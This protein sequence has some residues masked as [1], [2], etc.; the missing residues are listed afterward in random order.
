MSANLLAGAKEKIQT[1]FYKP[2]FKFGLRA[3]AVPLV[4]SDTYL[5]IWSPCN[6]LN[7]GNSQHWTGEEHP[8]IGALRVDGTTYRFMGKDR[9]C[10]LP[11]IPDGDSVGGTKKYWTAAY[12][13]DK[14]DGK[15]TNTA[16]DDSAWKT[17]KA[18]FGTEDMP[19]IGTPWETEDIWIRRTF[20]LEEGLTEETLVLQYSH[21]DVFELYLNG[22]RLVKTGY[23]WKNDV[24]LTLGDEQKKKLKNGKNVIAAHC[25]NT[26]GGAYVDFN[27]YKKAK[28][29]G[30][31][32]PAVQQSVDVLPTQT[33]YTFTCG[34]VELDLIFTAPLLPGNP[35]LISTPVNYISYRVRPLDGN[36]H[37][38]QL[39]METTPQLAVN[40]LSQPVV[41]ERIEKNGMIYLKTGTVDQEITKRQGDGVRIDWGYAYLASGKGK[42]KDMNIGDYYGMKAGFVETGALLPDKLRGQQVSD[43]LEAIPALAYTDQ[44][45][46][47]NKEGKTGYLMIGY[48]D[49]YSVEYFHKRL[50]AWWKH[51]GKIDIFRAFET[52]KANYESIMKKCRE[53][54]F[55]L[56]DG[57]QKAGGDEYAELCA[58]VF[59]QAIAAHKLLQDEDGEWL[60]LSKENHSGGFINT[61][62]ITYPSAP[63]FLI[64]N[65]D[66]LKGM[67]NGIFRYSESGRW[68]KPYPAHD[69]G[70]YPNANGQHYGED[71]PVEEAGNMILLATALSVVEGNAAYAQKHWETLTTWANFLKEKGLD[72]DNQL[73]TDDFAGH[74]A[75]NA[76]L[77]IKAIL[78]IAGYGRMAQMLGKND[79]AND[80]F[81]EAKEMAAQW[82][83]M[84]KDED[85]YRLAF[86]RP[87][88]WSQKYNLV[89]DKLLD[90]NIFPPDIAELEI[91]YYL[92]RQVEH[93]YGLP[94]DSRKA[95]TKADWIFWVA[96]MAKERETF[97]EII[98]SVYRYANETQS[99]VPI[100][101]FY[102]TDDGKMVNFKAR[103]VVGG[104][105]MKILSDKLNSSKNK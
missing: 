23:T 82:I 33:Y 79:L 80:C 66:L 19:H 30:F 50:M 71:M 11:L 24:Q 28:R 18:A 39:Y 63:L 46:Q 49:I 105:Y 13:F 91:P 52:A 43:L 101:D 44:L 94:L 25:H 93:K 37:D 83:T 6:R 53:F 41:S 64:Y 72:P 77:S 100:S 2:D 92:K 61:V 20:H 68:N 32:I 21:D 90:L 74:L 96:C 35:D 55:D 98:S 102:D 73:C 1:D 27:L 3:P 87:G 56:V 15:W 59:R 45:G 75:H 70:H 84:A 85:H 12:T 60:F 16:Y 86:D 8:L 97:R 26:T 34:P 89:W 40:D 51:E 7:E 47:V 54:D 88:T 17:G 103:S 58:L 67:M 31:D 29:P 81:A 104:F 99:R 65:P 38:I 78:G 22:E 9:P 57:A 95:Y 69:L 48:D 36:S 4:L 14:P 10:L 42:N 62:D 5:S 76:N